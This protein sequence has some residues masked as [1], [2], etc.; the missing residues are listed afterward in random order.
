M[1]EPFGRRDPLVKLWEPGNK[2]S[3]SPHPSTRTIRYLMAQV[4]QLLPLPRLVFSVRAFCIIPW[5]LHGFPSLI[6]AKNSN[7]DES[8]WVSQNNR[9]TEGPRWKGAQWVTPDPTS[10]PSRVIP[11]PI[12]VLMP[13]SSGLSL[14]C[15]H[16]L[17]FLIWMKSKGSHIHF[18]MGLCIQGNNSLCCHFLGA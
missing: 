8:I 4:L 7:R 11:E 3:L 1:H 12:A 2:P 14:C 15:W 18:K 13:D 10:C 6:Q 9:G 16:T 17:Q 5:E